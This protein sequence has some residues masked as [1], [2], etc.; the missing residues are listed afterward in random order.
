MNIS[1]KAGLGLLAFA[2]S[3]GPVLSQEGPQD[4]PPADP[5]G[6]GQVMGPGAGRGQWGER[7]TGFDRG[8]RGSRG[9]FGLSRLLSDPE[10]QQKIGITPEQ[11]AKI[12]QQESTFRK[13]E[14]RQRA[15]L[16]V[17][18]VDLHDLLA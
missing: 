12:R 17:K 9:D 5:G 11:V 1:S 18:K 7:R 4:P 6:P 2:L 16:Q 15:D 3:C 8:E 13:A 10:I 14:I